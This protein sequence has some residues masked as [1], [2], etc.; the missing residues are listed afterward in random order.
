MPNK[1]MITNPMIVLVIA[2][3]PKLGMN[4]INNPKEASL[5]ND[6]NIS[7]KFPLMSLLGLNTIVATNTMNSTT[8][9]PM[10]CAHSLD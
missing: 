1:T 4:A 8:M 3:T 10:T 5:Q 6:S 2:F 9:R 7:S